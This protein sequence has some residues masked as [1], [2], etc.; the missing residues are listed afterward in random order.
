MSQTG[1]KLFGRARW[2]CP[3]TGIQDIVR[4]LCNFVFADIGN[5]AV[6]GHKDMTSKDKQF[7]R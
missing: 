4:S 5:T 7:K 2:H 6:Y 1:W 3:N